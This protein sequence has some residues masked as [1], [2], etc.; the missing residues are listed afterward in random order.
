MRLVVTISEFRRSEQYM[1][2]SVK[3]FRADRK[4]PFRRGRATRRFRRAAG[5]LRPAG[6]SCR[7]QRAGGPFRPRFTQ[8]LA[9]GLMKSILTRTLALSFL[10]Q[11]VGFYGHRAVAARAPVPDGR[12]TWWRGEGSTADFVD[13]NS[14]IARGGLTYASGKFGQGFSC[15]GTDDF[16]RMGGSAMLSDDRS[17]GFIQGGPEQF[18]QDPQSI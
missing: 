12:V 8:A 14:G 13:L 3:N 7:R 17:L 2:Y 10:L 18:C 9:V 11:Y 15:N 16:I 4:V 5:A 6:A 1:K